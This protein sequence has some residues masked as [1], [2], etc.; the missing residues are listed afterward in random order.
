M[1]VKA[2]F[3]WREPPDGSRYE[4]YIA[5]VKAAMMHRARLFAAEMRSHAQRFAPW[6]DRT[7]H[8]RQRLNSRAQWEGNRLI[9]YLFHQMYYGIF[10]EL[11]WGGRWSI[12]MKT[13]ERFEDRIMA[14]MRAL[15]LGAA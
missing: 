10:L 8:A 6:T 2:P 14:A 3:S 7:A 15:W 1:I 11:R 12:L 9:I 5:R 13:L 4:A